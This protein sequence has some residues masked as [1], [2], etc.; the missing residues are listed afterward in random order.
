MSANLYER[1]I[2]WDAHRGSGT[3][4]ALTLRRSVSR[5]PGLP[6]RD[7]T[8]LYYVPQLGVR[9]LRQGCDRVREMSNEEA[10]AC[11]AYLARFGEVMGR[12]CA[13]G[14]TR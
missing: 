4:K 13:G 9:E 2:H 1:C 6:F 7:L 12:R 11:D 10:A 8:Y 3:V 5:P 14:P